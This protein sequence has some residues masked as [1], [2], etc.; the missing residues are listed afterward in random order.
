MINI[1]TKA[2]SHVG[3]RKKILGYSAL[4]IV[5]VLGIG[6]FGS[7]TIYQQNQSMANIIQVSQQKV[8]GVTNAR[9]AVVEMERALAKVIATEERSKIRKQAVAAIRSLSL[10][11]EQIQTLSETLKDSEEVKEILVLIQR[12]RPIQLQVIKEARKNNDAGAVEKMQSIT[13]DAQK[14][15]DLSQQLVEKERNELISEQDAL[16]KQGYIAITIMI[17]VVGIGLLLGIITSLFAAYLVTRPLS[18]V[19]KAM[20][21]LANGNLNIELTDEG[22]DEI[23]RT[24]NA[25]SITISNLHEIISEIHS[26]SELLGEHS[27]QIGKTAEIVST[28]STKLHDGIEAIK[29]DTQIVHS[30]TDDVAERLRQATEGADITSTTTKKSAQ[31]MLNTVKEFQRFQ[32]DMENTADVTRRLSVAA[33]QVTSI[34]DTIR[35]ISSQTNLLALNAAIEAARAG[36]QGRGFAVVAD[37]VRQLAKR[38]EDATAEI[39]T[40]VEEISA[41]VSTTVDALETSVSDAKD[42]IN[43]LTGLADEATVSSE[44]VQ[45]MR[46]YMTEVEGL[47][48]SQTQAVEGI[49]SSVATLFDVSVDANQETEQLHQLSQNLDKASSNLNSVVDRFTL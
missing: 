29:G 48:S 44:R 49:I 8:N 15:N 37:E 10:L 26:G 24:V 27:S 47:M 18:M 33:D 46:T 9:V 2:L 3:W 6:A 7:F 28:V 22:T 43:K 39:S 42:N 16:I 40:L 45:D 41:S 38:T 31:Q 21:S 23:G 11:D 20:T 19:E 4:Y 35:D 5:L 13:S 12:M 17:W 25:M 14:V 36:D 32:S 1:L 34:T 30:V